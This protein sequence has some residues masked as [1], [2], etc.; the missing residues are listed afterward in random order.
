MLRLL[1]TR[2]L[3]FHPFVGTEGILE[4]LL[5]LILKTKVKVQF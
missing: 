4:D 1:T 2:L 3:P 5:N